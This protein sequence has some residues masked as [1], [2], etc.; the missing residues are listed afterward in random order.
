MQITQTFDLID[1]YQSKLKRKCCKAI[2]T[3]I[4][5]IGTLLYLTGSTLSAI[6]AFFVTDIAITTYVLNGMAFL[7]LGLKPWH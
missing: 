2:I 4:G 1:N 5:L 6:S 7:Y 3:D